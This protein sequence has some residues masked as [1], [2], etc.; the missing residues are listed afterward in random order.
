VIDP[1]CTGELIEAVTL[2]EHWSL[3]YAVIGLGSNI[4]FGDQDIETV[5]IRTSG[6]D[7]V[8]CFPDGRIHA[9]CG[10]SLG[11]L[12]CLAAREGLRGLCF[13]AGIPGSIGGAVF[14]NAGTHAGEMSNVV[15][16]VD[17]F[18]PKT[19]EIKTLFNQELSFS[20]RKSRFQSENAVLIAATLQLIPGADPTELFGEMREL[21][22]ARKVKQPLDLP[23]IGSVFRRPSPDIAVSKIIDELGFKG[24]RIGGAEVS[25]KHAGFIVNVGGATARDVQTLIAEIQNTVEREK[26]FRPIPEIRFIP[27]P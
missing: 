12:A 15:E 11:R 13:A 26:G 1:C 27:E 6:L 10:V 2:C 20:Y 4:L 5:L 8:K 16:C 18:F 17:A 24:K 21:G 7:A 22:L 23:S 19:G 25:Q 9:L 14:M 3:P